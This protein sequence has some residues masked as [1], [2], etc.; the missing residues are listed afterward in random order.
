MYCVDLYSRF[1]KLEIDREILLGKASDVPARAV[2]FRLRAATKFLAALCLQWEAH[3]SYS[4]IRKNKSQE[5]CLR[6]AYLRQLDAECGAMT[7]FRLLYID[8]ATV[9]F[10][11]DAL[12]KG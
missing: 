3:G 6:V 1:N 2:A 8:F 11:D 4:K 5:I 12:H 9:I 10:L 7:E